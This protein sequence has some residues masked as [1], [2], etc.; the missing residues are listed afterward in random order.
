MGD[1]K[2]QLVTDNRG[3]ESVIGCQEIGQMSKNGKLL[4]GFCRN[5]DFFHKRYSLT[6]QMNTLC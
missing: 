1:F 2:A 6:S 5:Q 3:L 4:A